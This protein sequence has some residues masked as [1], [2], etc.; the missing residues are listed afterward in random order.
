MIPGAFFIYRI[1]SNK[2]PQRLLNLETKV[3]RLSEVRRSLEETRYCGSVVISPIDLQLKKNMKSI[4]FT[5]EI[6]QLQRPFH[7]FGLS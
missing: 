4:I 5:S 2:R 6:E 3:W 7:N 1:S